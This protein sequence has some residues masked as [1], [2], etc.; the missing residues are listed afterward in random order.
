MIHR[1]HAP[2][3]EVEVF[4]GAVAAAARTPG[5]AAINPYTSVIFTNSFRTFRFAIR[6]SQLS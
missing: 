1:P 4:F 6:K 5:W 3:P 2:K